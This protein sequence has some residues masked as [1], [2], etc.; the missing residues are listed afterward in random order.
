MGLPRDVV[1]EYGIIDE[2]VRDFRVRTAG[3]AYTDFVHL[4]LA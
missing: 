1:E 2:S 3:Q 4:P